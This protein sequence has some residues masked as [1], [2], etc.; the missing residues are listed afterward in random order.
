MTTAEF[1][2]SLRFCDSEAELRNHHASHLFAALNLLADKA[3]GGEVP[4]V[5]LISAIRDARYAFENTSRRNLAA[6]EAEVTAH[7]EASLSWLGR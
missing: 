6:K 3:N 4:L 5:E 1:N 2:A 7:D